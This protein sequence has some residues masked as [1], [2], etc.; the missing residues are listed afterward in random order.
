LRRVAVFAQAIYNAED[1]PI[2]AQI[3]TAQGIEALQKTGE[4][5]GRKNR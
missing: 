2:N 1:A 4:K 3:V 5:T